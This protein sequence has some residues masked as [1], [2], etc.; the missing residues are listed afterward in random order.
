MG[1][2]ALGG[3]AEREEIGERL[4]YF[5]SAFSHKLEET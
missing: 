1:A 4:H 3:N 2:I 5:G